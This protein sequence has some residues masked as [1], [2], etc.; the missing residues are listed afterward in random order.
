MKSLIVPI[1]NDKPEYKKY[2][3]YLFRTNS[4][5]YM[6][7]V[8]A[9]LGL[10]ISFFDKIFF[11]IL[12]EHNNKYFL[13]DAFDIQFRRL[14]LQ[15][16]VKVVILEKPTPNQPTTVYHT[17]RQENIHGL[18]MVKDADG[19]FCSKI[20]EGN[21]ISIFPIDDLDHINPK[22]KS[23][24]AIDDMFYVTNIIEK[25]I[26]SRWFSAGGYVFESAE[27]FCFYYEKLK[28]FP[29]LYISHIIYAM[30]LDK[31]VFRPVKVKKYEDWGSEKEFFAI[32]QNI[33]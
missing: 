13:K 18:I 2:I 21:N 27:I 33:K 30:L 9:I 23:Y 3:P 15:N 5:G 22:N 1:A 11:T 17:I 32:K 7:C 20:N 25:R 31:I 29:K 4:E 19:F 14:G 6:Y 26:I 10:E 24:V 12:A 28:Q 8:S 16:K